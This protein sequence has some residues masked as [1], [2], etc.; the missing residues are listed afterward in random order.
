MKYTPLKMTEPKIELPPH[1][2]MALVHAAYKSGDPKY[3]LENMLEPYYITEAQL[4]Y[5]LGKLVWH[6]TRRVTH[7]MT[8]TVRILQ[9]IVCPKVQPARQTKAEF[10]AVCTTISHCWYSKCENENYYLPSNELCFSPYEIDDRPVPYIWFN[11]DQ[12]DA[13]ILKHRTNGVCALRLTVER[14]TNM[15]VMMPYTTDFFNEEGNKQCIEL[16]MCI[17]SAQP[18]KR[19]IELINIEKMKKSNFMILI[20]EGPALRFVNCYCASPSTERLWRYP[21]LMHD[22]HF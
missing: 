3:C 11:I 10:I 20:T 13:P 19:V 14:E 4:A 6:H 9:S 8:Y 15:G 21:V 1:S 16:T 5:V 2:M 22:L 12:F 18:N 7:P 17:S